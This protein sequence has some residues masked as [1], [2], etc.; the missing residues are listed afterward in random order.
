[1]LWADLAVS[2]EQP[3]NSATVTPDAVWLFLLS[4]SPTRD[5]TRVVAL[6]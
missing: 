2:L 4:N 5:P 3:V 1:M 6:H